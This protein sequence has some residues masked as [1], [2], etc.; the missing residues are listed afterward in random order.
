[1]YKFTN[2]MIAYS[3]NMKNE[4]LKIGYKLVEKTNNKESKNENKDN[5]GVIERKP[6]ESDNISK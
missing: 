2:G 5:N 3:E 1:M 6:T 4:Y